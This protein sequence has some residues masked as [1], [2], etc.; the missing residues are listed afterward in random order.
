MTLPGQPR[1]PQRLS[2]PPGLLQDKRFLLYCYAKFLQLLGQNALIYGLFIA[3]ISE[4]DSSLATSAFVLASVVPS[5]FLS[6]PGGLVA[7]VL[8]RKP[9]LIAALFLRALIV[10]AFLGLAPGVEAVIGLTLVLWT[11]YQFYSPAENAA[12]L[13]VVPASRYAAA[14]SVLQAVSIAAQL[15]GAGALAPLLLRLVSEDGLYAVVLTLTVL[16]ML[17]FASVPGLT[18]AAQAASSRS[19]GWLASLAT[20]YRVI[21][22][23]HRLTS[24]TLLRVL[25]DV[26][27]L[28]VLVA[29]PEFV[30]E[31]LETSAEHAIYVAIPA[32]VGLGSG[33]VLAPWV[34][35][36]V[37]PRSLVMAGFALFT[38]TILLLAFVDGFAADAA[39]IIGPFRDFKELLGLGDALAATVLFLPFAGLGSSFAHVAAR[40]E[41]YRQAPPGVVAQ[42]FATQS[43]LGSVAALGPTLISG[44]LVDLL[45]VRF[46][47]VLIGGSLTALAAAAW[48][49][50]LGRASPRSEAFGPST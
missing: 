7:D 25:L 11:V 28:M 35:N 13:A 8:P 21:L 41:V 9:V 15:G 31:T 27:T 18:P 45:P 23:D 16:S 44:L 14:A 6:L 37:S 48:A 46:V 36:L 17:L 10:Y 22:R 19:Q 38:A 29:A 5:V 1:S 50:G 4:Q 32:A 40:T 26:G 43:A 49:A 34:L 33:L 2:S 39:L 42:V 3:V 20:G 12:L 24:I 47:L 30:E